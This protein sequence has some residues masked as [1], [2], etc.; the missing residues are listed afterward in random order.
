MDT[1]TKSSVI[2]FFT[3]SGI[4]TATAAPIVAPESAPQTVY[5]GVR[6]RAVDAIYVGPRGVTAATGYE[7]PAGSEL[8]LPVNDLSKVYVVSSSGGGAYSWI[9]N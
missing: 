2:D 8:F 9:A 1:I 7:L 5:K 4:A 3:G 6:L